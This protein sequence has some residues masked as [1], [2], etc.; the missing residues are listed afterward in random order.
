MNNNTNIKTCHE[1]NNA[2]DHLLLAQIA[3]MFISLIF[4]EK[5]LLGIDRRSFA[6]SWQ[7]L[8]QSFRLL[9]VSCCTNK[10]FN[11]SHIWY[12]FVILNVQYAVVVVVVI[13][14]V[15]FFYI[16]LLWHKHWSCN[17][18]P[19]KDTISRLLSVCFCKFFWFLF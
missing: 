15:F 13:L 8:S 6:M 18:F 9:S 5:C 19:F 16:V 10:F 14:L 2:C 12:V 3:K 1:I 17:K 11:I 4:C 7:M